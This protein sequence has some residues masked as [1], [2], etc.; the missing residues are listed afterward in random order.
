MPFKLKSPAPRYREQGQSI[1]ELTLMLP[2]LMLL[3]LGIIDLG[4]VFYTYVTMTNAAREGARYGAVHP[5]DN[6]GIKNRVI[7][8]GT[9]TAVDLAGSTV[10]VNCYSSDGSSSISCSDFPPAG[11]QVKVTITLNFQLF[12]TY[13]FGVGSLSLS[14]YAVMAITT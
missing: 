1:V 3:L 10:N 14:N 13:I 9:N 5:S 12:T 11:S 8:E 2:I 6:T 7:Q 4:R